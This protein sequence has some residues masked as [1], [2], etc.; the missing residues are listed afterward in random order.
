MSALWTNT[1][2]S[3]HGV[4]PTKDWVPRWRSLL[5]GFCAGVSLSVLTVYSLEWLRPSLAGAHLA[6]G[7]MPNIVAQRANFREADLVAVDLAQGRLSSADFR[8]A[9]AVRAQLERADLRHADLSEA[10]LCG[11]NLKSANLQY[12]RL[13][14]TNLCRADLTAA[15]LCGA[16]L[17]SANMS[18]A[19][20]IHA[21]Y[22]RSTRWPKGF[23]PPGS[24]LSAG[25]EN[26][27]APP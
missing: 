11:A 19:L 20:L 8:A 21:L 17:E 14:G 15:N 25:P 3:P 22:D 9:N 18:G 1:Q 4:P 2:L 10:N 23:T 13:A 6:H 16:D 5:L 27:N 7:Q 24:G 12:A 26:G